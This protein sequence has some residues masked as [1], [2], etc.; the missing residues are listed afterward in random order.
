MLMQ[1]LSKQIS[2]K[3]P[4]FTVRICVLP[5]G[6]SWGKGKVYSLNSIKIE[7]SDIDRHN[8]RKKP[9]RH[10]KEHRRLIVAD[11]RINLIG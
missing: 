1:D 4:F 3:T 2:D 8:M 5:Q 11:L 10:Q 6:A 9:L 7:S